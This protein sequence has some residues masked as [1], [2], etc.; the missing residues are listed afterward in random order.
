MKTYIELSLTALLAV[1]I[2]EKPKSLI[3]FAHHTLG[4][5]A[6]IGMVFLMAKCYGINAGILTS[7][8][9]IVLF[10]HI[11]EDFNNVKK[12]SLQKEGFAVINGK[13][14][15]KN[16]EISKTDILGLDRDLKM[17]AIR[18]FNSS[19]QEYRHCGKSSPFPK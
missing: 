6:L 19:S 16:Y 11:R 5:L 9:T 13:M 4:K 18:S 17:T 10:E 1:L 2:Y 8:I 15:K 7:L 12:K 3:Y 14:E